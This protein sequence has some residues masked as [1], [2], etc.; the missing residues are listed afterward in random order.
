LHLF[1]GQGKRLQF[2]KVQLCYRASAVPKSLPCPACLPASLFPSLAGT[3]AIGARTGITLCMYHFETIYA[4]Y[5]LLLAE[6]V[7]FQWIFV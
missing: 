3:E 5:A 6:L 1:K 7:T 2:N 4:G